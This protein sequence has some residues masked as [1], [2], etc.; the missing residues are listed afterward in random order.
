MEGFGLGRRVVR[1]PAGQRLDVVAL[2][3]RSLRGKRARTP[4]GVV[5]GD[6]ALGVN[7]EVDVRPQRVGDAPVGH[8]QVRVEVSRALE[9]AH[10]LVVVEGIDEAQ[11]LVEKLL[12]LGALRRDRVTERAHAFDERR[13]ILVSHR[14]LL[15][16]CQRRA[17]RQKQRE[18]K[19][20]ELHLTIL[21]SR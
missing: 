19:G 16:L 12:R 3:R 7:V 4:D 13:L 11:P 10:G 14:M 6:L 5:G 2:L 18:E 15:V 21:L 1:V 9:R 20:R 8:R 17:T